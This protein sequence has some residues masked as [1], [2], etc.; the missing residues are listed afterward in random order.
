MNSSIFNI[1]FLIQ[2]FPQG[3]LKACVAFNPLPENKWVFWEFFNKTDSWI[4]CVKYNLVA[5]VSGHGSVGR[6]RIWGSSTVYL[7]TLIAIVRGS[8]EFGTPDSLELFFLPP[9]KE[10]LTET[11][12]LTGQ[13]QLPLILTLLLAGH[14]LWEKTLDC[15]T[16]QDKSALLC[17]YSVGSQRFSGSWG[18]RPEIWWGIDHLPQLRNAHP[19]GHLCLTIH[20]PSQAFGNNWAFRETPISQERIYPCHFSIREILPGVEKSWSL[21]VAKSQLAWFWCGGCDS[22]GHRI[23]LIPKALM[24]LVLGNILPWTWGH[25]QNIHVALTSWGN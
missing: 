7:V 3:S 2:C 23:P 8:R 24:C 10:Q 5:V 19:H 9:R 12:A 6:K 15:A 14:S 18:P 13:A 11:R 16:S 4:C 22:M 25:N 20:Q 1:A 21:W 17:P